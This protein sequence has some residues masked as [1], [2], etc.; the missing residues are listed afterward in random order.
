MQN[1]PAPELTQSILDSGTVLVYAKIGN[2]N[3]VHQLN[4]FDIE[5]NVNYR[6]KPSVGSIE[7]D[8]VYLNEESPPTPPSQL[9]YVLMSNIVAMTMRAQ[10]INPANYN[11]VSQYLRLGK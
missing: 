9:R 1:I 5:E 2:S 8:T 3:E 7:V 10:H 11:E 6:F 4:Y